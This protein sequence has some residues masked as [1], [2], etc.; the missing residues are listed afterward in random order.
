MN[1]PAVKRSPTLL[2]ISAFAVVFGAL[3]LYSGGGVIFADGPARAA[4]GEYVG[5]VVWFN[6]L[7]GFFYILAGIGLYLKCKW[8]A[9]L[10]ALIAIATLAVFG[11]FGIHIM[12]GGTYEWRTVGAM[13]LR[14]VV[15]IGVARYARGLG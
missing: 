7:A 8:A 15:W 5:F 14:S 9:P 6:F 10:S 12:L 3:T 1:N 2:I 11:A 13:V 4:A